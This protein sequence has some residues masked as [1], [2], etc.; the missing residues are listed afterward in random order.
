[1]KMKSANLRLAL[2]AL[3]AAL[4]CTLHAQERGSTIQEL[5]AEAKAAETAGHTD[6]AIEKYQQMLRLSPDLAA[7]HNNLGRLYYQAGQF[8]KAIPELE[9][10]CKIDGH[11]EPPRALLGFAYFQMRKFE[12][13]RDELKIAASLNPGDRVA[14]LFLARSY[15]AT[16]E[17]KRAEEVLE[18]LRN[19]DPKNVEVL[20]ALGSLY[21]SLAEGAMG[22]IEEADPKSY[23]IEVMLAKVAEAKEL[24]SE[25]AEHYKKAIERAPGESELY[26]Q[27]GHALW[28]SKNDEEALK[29]YRQALTLNPYEYRASWEIARIVEPNDPAQAVQLVT[30]ALRVDPELPEAL[31]IR[32]QARMALSQTPQAI[33]DLTKS[34]ALDP[35]DATTHYELARAYRRAGLLAQAKEEESVFTQ[36]QSTHEG[37]AHP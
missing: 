30:D 35:K 26:Y 25:A 37:A 8:E 22:A 36:L 13:A 3:T 15:T 20:F 7:A 19:Q 9:R 12:Q 29:A 18:G 34:I 28:V 31:K 17:L 6:E 33:E 1:M 27:Y 10:A 4:A 21:S 14:G 11:L 32:G 24:Y 5:Y 23:L 2:W 16:G